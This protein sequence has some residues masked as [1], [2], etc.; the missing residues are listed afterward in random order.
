VQRPRWPVADTEGNI[1][2]AE[3]CEQRPGVTVYAPNGRELAHISTGK[4][5]PTN[6]GSGRGAEADILYVT[7]GKSRYRIRLAKRDYQLP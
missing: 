7:S 6:V 1:Y 4:E 5:L 3:R 2:V